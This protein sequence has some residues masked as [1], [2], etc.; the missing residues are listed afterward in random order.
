MKALLKF[1]QKERNPKTLKKSIKLLKEGKIYSRI[2][3]KRK[4]HNMINEFTFSQKFSI[5]NEGKIIREKTFPTKFYEI[6]L[7]AVIYRANL[8]NITYK[9]C[10]GKSL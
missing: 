7:F 9:H 8:Q 5:S 10:Q 6:N 3:N 1:L 4:F 2:C